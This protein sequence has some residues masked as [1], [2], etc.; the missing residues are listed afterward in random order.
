MIVEYNKRNHLLEE[1]T[2]KPSLQ[3]VARPNLHRQI[4]TYGKIPKIAFNMRHV[5]MECPKE[6]YISDTTFR[7]GQ[8]AMEPFSVDNIVELFKMLHRLG[9]K[10]GIIR[11]S[12][13]FL[14]SDKD[15]DAVKNALIWD[16]NFPKLQV[17]LEQ[18]KKILS[19]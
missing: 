1:H 14:Y 8:Q 9:G 19:S 10:N 5:P 3:D 15:K 2:Y 16:M 11:Q 13:F 18:T 7:D 17:G 4:F 6:L 12:E